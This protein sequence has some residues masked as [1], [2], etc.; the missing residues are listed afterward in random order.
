VQNRSFMRPMNSVGSSLPSG[1]SRPT[2][3]GRPGGG[4][5]MP[6]SPGSRPAGPSTRPSAPQQPYTNKPGGDLIYDDKG[7]P[8][9]VPPRS[10]RTEMEAVT[11]PSRDRN[12]EYNSAP[13]QRPSFSEPM[14]SPAPSRPS[15]PS[16]PNQIRPSTPSMPNQSRP[17]SVSPSRPSAP[18]SGG[19]MSNP[20]GGS[21]KG[22]P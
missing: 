12:S 11:S 15:A 16:S 22:R 5:V 21:Y 8:N 9:Y 3:S 4:Y 14:N 6:V 17:P 13:Q 20:G 2:V 19:T 7:R 1:S 10:R 18:A